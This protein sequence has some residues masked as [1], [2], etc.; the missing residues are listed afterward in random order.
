VS[1]AGKRVVITGATSGI[2]LAASRQLAQLGADLTIVGRSDE[3]AR[4]ASETISRPVDILLADFSSQRSVRQ[5]ADQLLARYERIDVLV[6]NAGAI[7]ATRQLS[8]D[9]IELTWAVNHLAPFLLTSLLLQRL[10][11]SAPARIITTASGAHYRAHIPFDDLQAERAYTSMGYGRYGETK[12]ANIL[13]T[14]EL[15]RRI[16]GSGVTANCFHPGFVGTGFGHNNGWMMRAGMSI[17]RLFARTPE[18]GAE[19]LVWLADSPDV[20]DTSGGYFVDKRER[21]P[22]QAARDDAA[23]SR[24]WELSEQQVAL[25]SAAEKSQPR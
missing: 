1:V 3:R 9:G 24:L 13:F 23:A 6:N 4:R 22:S 21:Q 18:K 8:K 15:A 5:L 19:T 7:Y 14:R 2:G 17:G 25:R 10:K 16:A 11:D 12:L 20:N